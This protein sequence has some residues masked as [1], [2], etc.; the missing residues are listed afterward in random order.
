[1]VT[2][3]KNLQWSG[4]V[5][6]ICDDHLENDMTGDNRLQETRQFWDQEAASFDDQADHGLND[7]LVLNTWMELQ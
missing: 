2:L 7:P 4:T 1:M 6:L 3:Q 5:F